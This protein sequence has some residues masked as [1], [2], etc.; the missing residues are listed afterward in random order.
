MSI[1][2]YTKIFCRNIYCQQKKAEL[3]TLGLSR[4]SGLPLKMLEELEKG[5]IPKEMM[6]EDA[7]DL[8]RAFGCEVYELFQ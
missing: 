6:V 2:E 8:A 5:V 1:Q 3:S 4:R 7:F